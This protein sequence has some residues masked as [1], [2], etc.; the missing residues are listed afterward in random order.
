MKK[1]NIWPRFHISISQCF[2]ATAPEV[3]ENHSK[4]TP[5]M[6]KIQGNILELIK[7]CCAELKRE[8][9]SFAN[10]EFSVESVISH[11]FERHVRSII[12]PISF[13]VGHK[14]NQFIADL[15]TL[16]GLLINLLQRDCV[17]FYH[18]INEI[19]KNEEVFSSNTGW[20]FLKEADNLFANCKERVFGSSVK[21]K[22]APETCVL[23]ES[24]KWVAL[25]EILKEI[26]HENEKLEDK[27]NG[28]IFIGVR[29]G[30]TGELLRK[31]LYSGVKFLQ[32][33]MELGGSEQ[34][35]EVSNQSEIHKNGQ[36]LMFRELSFYLV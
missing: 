11:D 26:S 5:L 14:T 9:S 20:L 4:L 33:E 30:K 6:E 23:E 13:S 3:L 7:A 27:S 10:E 32:D 22:G 28:R 18:F 19:R 35:N 12:D 15:K 24:P 25:K 31:Y 34:R 36:F 2:D 1:L 16:R 8:N 29:D 17:S 21:E